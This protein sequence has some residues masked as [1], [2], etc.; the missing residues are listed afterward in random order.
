MR[1][2]APEDVVEGRFHGQ[3]RPHWDV[4]V[5]C[6]RGRGASAA[7]VEALGAA[8]LGCTALWGFVASADNPLVHQL[9]VG[10]LSVCVVSHCIWGGP[11]AAILVE[12]LAWLGVKQII[13]FGVAGGL[14]P[15]LPQGT[16]ILAASGLATDG[17]SLAYTGCDQVGPDPDLRAL[18]AE[19]EEPL[20][21]GRTPVSIATVDA[22]YRETEIAVSKW[23]ARG[24]EAINMETTP[25][26]AASLA[27]GVQSIW[28]GHI[29][30]SLA[31]RSW[32][33]WDSGEHRRSA[34]AAGVEVV[35]RLLG[36]LAR[37]E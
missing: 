16:P 7:M 28:F 35:G 33:S 4:A 15:A 30:D 31:G 10:E 25:L 3:A 27:C 29:S 1:Y 12:E 5:L 36:R 21:L 9:R 2:I 20:D 14:V 18:L 19:V 6:F 11:Q 23:R 24:A 13:G 22:V 37:Q 34:T 32:Q 8:P 17:T 26:Y